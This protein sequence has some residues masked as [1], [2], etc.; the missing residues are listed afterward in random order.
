M[1]VNNKKNKILK[2]Q[3]NT[4]IILYDFETKLNNISSNIKYYSKTIKYFNDEL[5]EPLAN[6]LYELDQVI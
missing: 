4:K 6:E 3:N 1:V 5:F 2:F